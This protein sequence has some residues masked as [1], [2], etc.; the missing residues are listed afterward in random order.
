MRA[1]GLAGR[2]GTG[3][4][5][6]AV[7]AAASPEDKEFMDAQVITALLFLGYEGKCES[8]V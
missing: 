8:T 3:V 1:Q 4:Q 7:A 5:Y 2:E 6:P